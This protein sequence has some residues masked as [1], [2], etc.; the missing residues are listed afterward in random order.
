MNV[1][2]PNKRALANTLSTTSPS[3]MD[4]F[5]NDI[6]VKRNPQ[7]SLDSLPSHARKFVTTLREKVAYNE[8]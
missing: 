6:D 1:G 8:V 4:V 3:K 2:Q 5:R 7:T